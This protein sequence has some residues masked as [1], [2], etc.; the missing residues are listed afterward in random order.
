ME[1]FH[2]VSGMHGQAKERRRWE[3]TD[4]L[5]GVEKTGVGAPRR[6]DWRAASVGLVVAVLLEL[7]GSAVLTGGRG[8]LPGPAFVTFPALVLGGVTA[9]WLGPASGAVW[10][11]MIV[12]IGFIGV[13]ALVPGP[14]DMTA[15]VLDD[16]VMLSGG[17]LGGWLT[18]RVRR[19]VGR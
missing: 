17:S 16:L 19:L 13:A 2:G 10:N 4:T 8:G 9:G 18:G 3:A 14:T 1:P 5:V 7:A 15:L 11:G 12:A 6:I